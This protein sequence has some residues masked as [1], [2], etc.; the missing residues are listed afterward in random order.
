[1]GEGS[2]RLK[3]GILA[4]A[5]QIVVSAGTF[6]ST[7]LICRNCS[8]ADFGVFSLAWTIIAFLRTIQERMIASPFLAFTFRPA[9]NRTSFRGSTLAHQAV[10]ST[11]S[12]VMVLIAAVAVRVLGFDGGHFLFGLSLG[13]ALWST[14]GRDQM[15][16]VSFT[17]FAI[18]RLLILD[19][20]VVLSQLIGLVVLIRMDVFSLSVANLVLSFGCLLPIAAWLWMT[21]STYVIDNKAVVQDWHH[22]W[23]YARWLVVARVFGIA[24]VVVIPWLIFSFEGDAGTG[25]FGA[26]TSLVGVSLMFVQGANNVFQPRTMLELQKNGIR[27]LLTAIGESTGVICAGLICISTVFFFFGNNL[28]VILGTQYVGFGFLTFLLS[29]STLVISISTM[30]SNGLAALKKSKDFFWG[31]VSYC[32]VSI[33]SALV[34]IPSQGLNGAAYAMILGGLAVTIVT[35][36]RLADG[37]HN[38]AAE[39]STNEETDS[40]MPCE[41]EQT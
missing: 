18:L 8:D 17:D 41:R 34:L 2:K 6:L 38:Y 1:M 10:F 25:V 23:S 36:V 29:V 15:R 7:M 35:A 27:G 31:E 32:V 33:V 5:D 13:L 21:R 39:S 26:C 14:L 22:N 37:V 11:A 9:F 28:L 24:P 12:T 30:L 40:L 4:I 16:Y 3:N 20:V 19:V